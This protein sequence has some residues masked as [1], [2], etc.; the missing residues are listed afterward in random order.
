[1][2][3]MK[4]KSSY[5][6]FLLSCLFTYSC[7][8]GNDMDLLNLPKETVYISDGFFEDEDLTG[9]GISTLTEQTRPKAGPLKM[10]Q[11]NRPYKRKSNKPEE[12]AKASVWYAINAVYPEPFQ[13]PGLEVL[14]ADLDASQL[15]MDLKISWRDQWVSHPY[16]IKG[17]LKVRPDGSQG[18]FRIKEKNLE[19]EALEL[20]HANSPALIELPQL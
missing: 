11:L 10:A 15:V 6:L 1:M 12:L 13:S 3:S 14:K 7:S 19:A 16:I 9:Q 2:D 18:S 17:Q 8:S 20:T 4:Y 5:L